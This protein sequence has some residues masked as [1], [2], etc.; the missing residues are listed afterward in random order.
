[1]QH[2]DE[3]EHWPPGSMQQPGVPSMPPGQSVLEPPAQRHTPALSGWQHF[4]L[5]ESQAQQSAG[6]GMSVAL[7]TLPT[8]TQPFGLRQRPM[9]GDSPNSQVIVPSSVPWSGPGQQSSVDVH[10]SPWRR[11]PD[12]IWQTLTPEDVG[13]QNRLQQ[14][15]PPAQMSPTVLHVN[16]GAQRFTPGEI[17]WQLVEQHW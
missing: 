9:S 1:M 2:S 14:S 4:H 3:N 5:G 15:L 10:S 7:Q 13:T 11:Q 16:A 17:S 8:G 6:D 12:V